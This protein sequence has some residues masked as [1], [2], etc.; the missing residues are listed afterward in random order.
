MLIFIN[1]HLKSMQC[2]GVMPHLKEICSS[3]LCRKEENNLCYFLYH[4]WH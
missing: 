1:A 4:L 3:G 2:Y